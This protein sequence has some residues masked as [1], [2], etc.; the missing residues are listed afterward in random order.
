MYINSIEISNFRS[1][2]SNPPLKLDISNITVLSGINDTGKTSALLASFLGL[3]SCINVGTEMDKDLS[4]LLDGSTHRKGFSQDTSQQCIRL[5]LKCTKEDLEKLWKYVDED[6]YFEKE[7][8]DLND[9]RIDI[10]RE[11]VKQFFSDA[12]ILLSLPLRQSI[13]DEFQSYVDFKSWNNHVQEFFGY[14]KITDFPNMLYRIITYLTEFEYSMKN[15]NSL[16]VP[17][18]TRSNEQ[19]F[20]KEEDKK[21][22]LVNYFKEICSERGKTS[23]KYKTS[24]EYFKILLPEL[25]RVEINRTQGDEKSE[26]IFLI[27]NQ[28]GNE[29][30]QPLSRSGDG[31]YNTM[32]FVAKVLN[33]FSKMNIVFIDE[34]EIGLHPM[35]QQRFIKLIRKISREF[36]IQW[37]LA[38]H[39]P[40]ILQSLKDKEKL[41]LIKHDGQQTNCQE[42]DI[43]NKDV[44]FST[45]GAY[46]PL[47]LSATGVI[48]V[49]GQ[50]EVT[51]L[52]ILL[53]KVGLNIERERILIIPLGGENLFQI[54]AKDLKKLHEKSMVIIDSDLPKSEAE[55]GNIKQVK[56]DYKDECIENN[57][58]FLMIKDYRTL[59]NMYPKEILAD[60][61]GKEVETL[62]YG[63]FDE[64]PGIRNKIKV[65]EEVAN[66]MSKEEAERF[67]LIKE[68]QKWWNEK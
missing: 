28:N 14:D 38:T 31:I 12:V 63:N 2:G 60:V 43:S 10:Q 59:E 50:T 1:I 30:E 56:S 13:F 57:V 19:A 66:K 68:I 48:F 24:M 49:E 53:D 54:D 51:I 35:L 65:G 45:L 62:D 40:F 26:D 61:L 55:G 23:G 42:I 29:K 20:S 6:Q 11:K 3:N 18:V 9:Q 22:Q 5:S 37:V 33:N 46:L 58:E 39:S 8:K 47:A 36:S 7:L 32:F 21:L 15:L 17:G 52:T 16:Y 64:V 25:V 4:K 44:V 67:P 41:Y 27:W 34:P